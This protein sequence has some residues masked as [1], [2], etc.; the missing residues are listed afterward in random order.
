MKCVEC[1]KTVSNWPSWL[2]RTRI[3]VR[4]NAC[5]NAQPATLNTPEKREDERELAE[6][7]S[8]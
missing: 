7:S 5:A 4:C 1:G 3:E 2:E 8:R 6:A